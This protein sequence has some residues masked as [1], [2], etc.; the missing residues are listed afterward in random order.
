MSNENISA[1]RGGRGER[2]KQTSVGFVSGREIKI[3]EEV[4][5][6]HSLGQTRI[7][8]RKK[9]RGKGISVQ[10]WELGTHMYIHN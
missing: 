8:R 1:C 4:T 10:F 2:K 6:I 3:D 5:D 9:S 7:K